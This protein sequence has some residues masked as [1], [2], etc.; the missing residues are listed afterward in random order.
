MAG[1][2]KRFFLPFQSFQPPPQFCY[3]VTLLHVTYYNKVVPHVAQPSFIVPP[4]PHEAPNRHYILILVCV[5]FE[6]VATGAGVPWRGCRFRKALGPEHKMTP[7]PFSLRYLSHK[8]PKSITFVGDRCTPATRA[9]SM[10]H[11]LP[12]LANL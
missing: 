8:F 2:N 7:K 4:I 11:W 3:I 10:N 6:Q 1:W 12:L 9:S 5:C